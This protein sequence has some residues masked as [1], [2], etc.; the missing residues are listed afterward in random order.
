[1]GHECVAIGNILANDRVTPAMIAAFE[2]HPQNELADRLLEAILAGEAAG[3]EGG[4]LRAAALQVVD[5]S[6]LSVADLRVDASSDPLQDLTQLWEEFRSYV[7]VFQT[8]ALA[9][10][11]L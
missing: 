4:P 2:A 10:H 1:Q 8:R 7:K 3:G 11:T 5:R 9:P 6:P